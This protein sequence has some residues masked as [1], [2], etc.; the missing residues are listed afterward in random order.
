MKKMRFTKILAFILIVLF[1]GIM[2]VKADNTLPGSITSDGYRTVTYITAPTSDGTLKQMPIIVKKM[3]DGSYAFCMELD[4]TYKAGVTWK[5]DKSVDPGYIY[6]LQHSPNTGDPDK[7]FYI[8]QMAV[9]Y[10]SD[11]L[12]NN[13]FNLGETYKKYIITQANKDPKTET[14]PI[15]KQNIEVCA[16]IMEL[17]RNAKTYKV[18]ESSIK[19]DGGEKITFK[20]EGEYFVSSEI[21]VITKS[22]SG[23]LSY[24]LTQEPKG[25]MIMP[26]SKADT[27]Y[28]KIPVEKVPEGYKVNPVLT[29]TG[30]YTQLTAFSYFATSAYQRLLFATPLMETKQLSAAIE[31]TL[32]NTE[33]HPVKV[34]K[35]NITQSAEVPGATLVIKDSTGKE[36]EK[37]VSTDK[38]RT[39]ELKAGEYSLPEPSLTKI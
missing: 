27:V 8:M 10:Y 21:K 25:S 5:K 16:G 19:L 14:D 29:V 30:P 12:N 11:Y 28:V 34:S 3:A 6:I 39:V 7:D 23:N 36:I 13:N 31:M 24:K 33:K 17:Y 9:W 15:K 1:A 4:S 38:P 18:P 26:G 20:V 22:I 37:W 32:E 2:S 35:T